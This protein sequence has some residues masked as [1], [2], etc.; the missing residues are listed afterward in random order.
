MAGDE[1]LPDVFDR[2]VS[3]TRQI[4]DQEHQLRPVDP[5]MKDDIVVE[6][7]SSDGGICVRAQPGKLISIEIDSQKRDES[8]WTA[9]LKEVCEVSNAALDEAH[10]LLMDQYRE[11]NKDFD[12]LV[13]N[14]SYLQADFRDA[15]MKSIGQMGLE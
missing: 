2:I 7:D 6:K 8:S 3:T 12:S 11:I 14:L 5:D 9:L 13:S 4:H 15:F 10:E 1:S